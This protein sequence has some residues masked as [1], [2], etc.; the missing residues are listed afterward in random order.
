MNASYLDTQIPLLEQKT[1]YMSLTIAMSILNIISTSK[2]FLTKTT[3]KY[4]IAKCS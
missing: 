1:K 3:L 4:I 2:S